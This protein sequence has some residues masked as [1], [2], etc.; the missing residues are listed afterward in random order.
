MSIKKKE[1]NLTTYY[2]DYIIDD[3]PLEEIKRIIEDYKKQSYIIRYYFSPNEFVDLKTSIT[4]Q[5]IE[6]DNNKKTITLKYY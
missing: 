6:A 1:L 5:E 2:I 3:N 4:L